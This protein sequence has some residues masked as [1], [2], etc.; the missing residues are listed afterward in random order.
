MKE[1]VIC[2]AS[3]AYTLE[4]SLYH[5]NP[6]EEE[7]YDASISKTSAGIFIMNLQYISVN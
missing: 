3:N 2:D 4:T 6:D 7:Q 1:Y 5:G